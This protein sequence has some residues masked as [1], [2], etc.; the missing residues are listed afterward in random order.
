MSVVQG[1]RDAITFA[2]QLLGRTI[3]TSNVAPWF[4]SMGFFGMIINACS[5]DVTFVFLPKFT[6]E[7]FLKCIEEYKISSCSVVPPIMVFLAK[8]PMVD[9]YDLSSLISM[10]KYD[11]LLVSL[12]FNSLKLSDIAC[13][14][15][16][17]SKEIEDQVRER[18]LKN[19][20]TE[21]IIRQAY[22]MSE[23]TLR[24]IASTLIIKPGSV[25][26]V[27][28]GIYC[29]VKLNFMN[30]FYAKLKTLI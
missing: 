3:V 13:G 7:S 5:R 11:F 26:E 8:S 10:E 17:L 15:A 21:V 16:T 23:S 30:A 18:F 2:T 1:M 25:G 19:Y 22:G 24:T 28:P 4:H 6:N 20:K 14:A 27:L 29:K 12:Y 9:K